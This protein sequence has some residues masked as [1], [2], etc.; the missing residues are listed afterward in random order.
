MLIGH[1]K[2]PAYLSDGDRRFPNRF[3]VQIQA[4]QPAA[5][6]HVAA[7]IAAFQGASGGGDKDRIRSDGG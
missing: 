3:F 6:A 5:A 4:D 1:K 7:R 2:G